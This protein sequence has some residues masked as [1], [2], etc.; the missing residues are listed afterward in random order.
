MNRIGTI[1]A[2]ASATA[3]GMMF[4]AGHVSAQQ[5]SGVLRLP[6]GDSP[7]IAYSWGA[8]NSGTASG[9]GGAGSGRVNIQDISITRLTDTQSPQIFRTLAI[10]QH[11]PFVEIETGTTKF[12]FEDVIVSSYSTGGAID[13]KSPR[14]D[15]V[16]FNFGK[17]T[18]TV[19][20]TSTCFDL[21][22]NIAC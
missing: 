9:G 14:T 17:V 13:N 2:L 7:F 12:R 15:N 22:T 6:T 3:I 11:L 8:S 5:V 19:N 21:R 20:G 10:G 18:Y 1:K 4:V 16:T